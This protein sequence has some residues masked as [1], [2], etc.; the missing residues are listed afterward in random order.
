[1]V[2]M[3]RSQVALAF[4]ERGADFNTLSPSL[5]MDSSRWLA[6]NAVTIGKQE[7]VLVW[8]PD[9]LP[10]LLQGPGRRRLRR[11]IAMNQAAAA[12]LDDHEYVQLAKGRRNC[13][14]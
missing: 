5:R 11:D 2:P 4:G 12:V 6:K 1:M 3:T 13:D 9:H 10:Q 8:V 14:E 7:F